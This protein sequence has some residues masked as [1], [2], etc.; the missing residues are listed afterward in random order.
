MT[1]D[2]ICLHA[3]VSEL[4]S[5]LISGRLQK[6]NQINKN[7]LLLTIYT[8]KNYKLVLSSNSQDPRI[9]ISNQAFSNPPSPSN[10]TMILRKHLINSRLRDIRQNGLDRTV[11][12]IFD[13]KNELGLDT[14]RR[15]VIDLMGRQ[16]NIVLID[17]N[18]KVIEAITRVSHDMS[19]VRAIYPGTI[20]DQLKSDKVDILESDSTLDDLDIADNLQAFKIFYS[21]FTG[22]SPVIGR[23]ICYRADVDSKRNYGSLSN[24]EKIALNKAFIEI[25]D[26]IR[27]EDFNP[28]L[29]YQND[30]LSS[31]YCMDLTH[32]GNEGK[33]F[34]TM[35]ETLDTYYLENSN[36]DS[37]NQNKKNLL[38][39]LEKLV[40]KKSNK[41]D[42]MRSDLEKSKGFDKENQEAEVLSANVF[43]VKKGMKEISLINYYTNEE[44]SI[45]LDPKLD[46]WQNVEKK[47]KKSKKHKRSYNMLKKSIP[48]QIEECSYLRAIT[49]QINHVSDLDE[50]GEI[51]E[52]LVGQGYLKDKRKKKHKKR[53]ESQSRAYKFLTEDGSTI[54]VGKNNKQN[55]QITLKDASKEDY[56]FHVKD[57][58]GSHVILTND[59]G[60][61]T[62]KDFLAA[63]YLAAKYSK[64]GDEKYLDV[65][66]TKRKNV[67]K[68]KGAKPGMVYYNDF[69]TIRIDLEETISGLKE[70]KD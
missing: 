52:E 10:F 41:L 18:R 22:F 40:E 48:L 26:L 45:P 51:R 30:R 59:R 34:S 57:L 12:L 61:Y 32:L 54:F 46:P 2:G 29:I 31:F 24:E 38:Q 11:E 4:R 37:L 55:E 39:E 35:S 50:L 25:R 27:N 21:F 1:I 6:I 65:D 3:I 66:Y 14:E 62:E 67:F 53:K 63:G 7:L 60:V 47:Y 16:S 20:L 42:L 64:F 49:R 8:D 36:D 68:A 44:L 70:I 9:H 33:Y 43:Q 69:K 28:K 15:L 23:E 58:P 17:E 56:F 19:R 5:K 13:G